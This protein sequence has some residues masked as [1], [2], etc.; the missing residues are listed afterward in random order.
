M[1]NHRITLKHSKADSGFI[2]YVL[3]INSYIVVSGLIYTYE[4]PNVPKDVRYWRLELHN[5]TEP[6]EYEPES[7]EERKKCN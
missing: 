4:E 3:D 6:T 5:T 7:S 2:S 1:S